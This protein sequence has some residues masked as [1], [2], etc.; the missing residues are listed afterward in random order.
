MPTREE[1]YGLRQ[2][3]IQSHRERSRDLAELRASVRAEIREFANARK[4]MSAQLWSNLEREER[5][6]IKDSRQRIKELHRLSAQR[7]T[8][9]RG[10]LMQFD[11]EMH[12]AAAIEAGAR[13]GWRGKAVPKPTY[14]AAPPIPRATAEAPPHVAAKTPDRP[15]APKKIKKA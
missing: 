5:S 13:A 9:V 3:L 12:K 14:E 1:M 2:S 15:A 4:Q 7:K 8:A 10:Q 11:A 6:E